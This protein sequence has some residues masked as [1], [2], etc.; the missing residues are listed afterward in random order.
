MSA[1]PNILRSNANG[2]TVNA[3]PVNFGSIP[4]A[5]DGTVAQ[6]EATIVARDATNGDTAS[7]KFVGHYERSGG[8]TLEVLNSTVHTSE[9]DGTWA[10]QLLAGTNTVEV[11]VTGDATN[12]VHWSIQ[13]VAHLQSI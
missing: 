3:T 5:V 2:I 8:T 11:E 9:E 6:V 13:M 10:C 12:N 1:Q 7:Y 4:I